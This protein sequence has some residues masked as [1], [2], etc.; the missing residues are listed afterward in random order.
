LIIF[1]DIFQLSRQFDTL[2]FFASSFAASPPSAT[3]RLIFRLHCFFID[4]C[5]HY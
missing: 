3:A 2:F 4:S 1:F 5:R